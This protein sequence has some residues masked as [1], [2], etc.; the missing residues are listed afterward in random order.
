[1]TSSVVVFSSLPDKRH[2][3]EDGTEAVRDFLKL[4]L[5]K[6][7]KDRACG[8]KV[9]VDIVSLL[10]RSSNVG[11]EGGKCGEVAALVG[12]EQVAHLD[13]LG[14]VELLE[15]V[16]QIGGAGLPEV[17]LNEGSQGAVNKQLVSGVSLE[18]IAN[19]MGPFND[20][21]LDAVHHGLGRLGVTGQLLVLVQRLNA[22]GLREESHSLDL[23]RHDEG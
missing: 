7:L 23:A 1:M 21:G 8:G 2:H 10:E 16:Q 5:L 11:V 19:L 15:D 6:V 22:R 13:H 12:L 14:D 4:A 3:T 18:N 20:V 17:N 9:V